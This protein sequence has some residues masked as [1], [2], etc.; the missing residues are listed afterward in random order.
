MIEAESENAVVAPGCLQCTKNDVAD[1]KKGLPRTAPAVEHIVRR[2][3]SQDNLRF[4]LLIGER[5]DLICHP[6]SSCRG[7]GSFSGRA[8]LPWNVR[9]RR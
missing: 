7:Y 9:S 5:K 1:M 4:K 8:L 6:T 3:P 2:T